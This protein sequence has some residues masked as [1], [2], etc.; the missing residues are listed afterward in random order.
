MILY[1][2][3]RSY[4][5][6][7]IVCLPCIYTIRIEKHLQ[8][9]KL[10]GLAGEN[11]KKH[12]NKKSGESRTPIRYN[13][14]HVY[15]FVKCFSLII[16]L[17]VV[18]AIL[19]FQGQSCHIGGRGTIMI[20]ACVFCARYNWCF[21]MILL[22]Q[23]IYTVHPCMMVTLMEAGRWMDLELTIDCQL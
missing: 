12:G 21:V 7:K 15:I 18:H 5:T 19:V 22:I 20:I 17:T 9:E 2:H 13:V 8:C 11:T 4:T 23:G 16:S 3:D 6:I 10:L 1:D 14:I